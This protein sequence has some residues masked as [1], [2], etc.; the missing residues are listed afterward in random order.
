MADD[1]SR[2]IGARHLHIGGGAAPTV[3]DIENLA[4]RERQQQKSNQPAPERLFSSYLQQDEA[5]APG[6]DGLGRGQGEGEGES[7]PG[8]DEGERGDLPNASG[9][10]SGASAAT[11]GARPPRPLVPVPRGRHVIKG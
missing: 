6:R 10:P 4:E 1:L 7:N 8:P 5:P 11:P 9:N 3:A 2:R